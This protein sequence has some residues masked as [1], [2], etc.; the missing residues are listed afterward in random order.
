VTR[1]QLR[2]G[3]WNVRPEGNLFKRE[4]IDVVD[5]IPPLIR[6]A[7]GWDFAATAD[8]PGTDPDYTAGVK[9]G[10]DA[11][12]LFYVLD[13]IRTRVTPHERA[14]LVRNTAM[15]D[16]IDVA[17]RIEQEPGSS[18]VDVI[19][20]YV[21]EVLPEFNCRGEHTTGKDKV[22]RAQNFSAAAGNR[23]VKLLGGGTWISQYLDELCAFPVVGHDDQVDASVTAHKALYNLAEIE[24]GFFMAAAG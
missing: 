12:G 4:W 13:V 24:S 16:G 11:D 18:G 7:R 15:A 6:V 22:V 1:A 14:K 21:R 20:K 17:I 8:K 3:D 5:D 9:I 2:N 23:R 10:L 19:D